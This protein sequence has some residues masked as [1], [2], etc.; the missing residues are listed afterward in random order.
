[1]AQLTEALQGLPEKVAL[2]VREAM[3]STPAPAKQEQK[4]TET[5]KTETPKEKPPGTPPAG[6]NKFAHWW[7]N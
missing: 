7:F 2:A 1:V 4:Q 5:V 6:T 3:P